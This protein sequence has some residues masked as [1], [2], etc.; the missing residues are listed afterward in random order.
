MK[1]STPSPSFDQSFP[2]PNNDSSD[3]VL[4]F[5]VMDRHKD[6]DSVIGSATILLSGEDE[7]RRI[8]FPTS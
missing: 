8:Y 3:F 6:N 4:R 2:L 5:V 7:K 1:F